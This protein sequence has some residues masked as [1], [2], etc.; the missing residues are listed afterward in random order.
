MR[1]NTMLSSSLVKN[2]LTDSSVSAVDSPRRRLPPQTEERRRTNQHTEKTSRDA[3][4]ELEAERE[5][6]R[7]GAKTKRSYKTVP[8]AGREQWLRS[9]RVR[10]CFGFDF[11]ESQ[12]NPSK[13]VVESIKRASWPLYYFSYLYIKVSIDFHIHLSRT[14]VIDFTEKFTYSKIIWG[15]ESSNSWG[16]ILSSLHSSVVGCWTL[17]RHRIFG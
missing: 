6:E 14:Y 4:K 3:M 1:L 8:P 2:F 12:W 7:E 10:E 5:R 13:F 9:A 17:T 11:R 15:F 16:T